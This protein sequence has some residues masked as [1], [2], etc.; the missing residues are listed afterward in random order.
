[1]SQHGS[2]TDEAGHMNSRRTRTPKTLSRAELPL[3][4]IIP[5]SWADAVP[6]L[7]N[8][9]CPPPD[10]VWSN[11]FISLVPFYLPGYSSS[12]PGPP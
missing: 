9:F 11:T 7:V 2:K 12:A 1:M 10:G 6:G 3:P 5:F 4:K 8:Q